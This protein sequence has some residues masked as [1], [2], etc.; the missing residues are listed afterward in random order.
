MTSIAVRPVYS[1][2]LR[3]LRGYVWGVYAGTTLTAIYAK[4][5]SKLMRELRS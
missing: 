3:S 5:P 2:R 1:C 4:Y